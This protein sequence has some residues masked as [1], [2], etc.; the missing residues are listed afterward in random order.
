MLRNAQVREY[1]KQRRAEVQAEVNQQVV[2]DVEDAVRELRHVYQLTLDKGD[3]TNALRACVEALQSP[4]QIR[5]SQRERQHAGHAGGSDAGE[6]VG[7][8]PER[9]PQAQAGGYAAPTT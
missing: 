2:Y 5:H 3:L 9:G 1:L 8:G 4:R 6:D 7:P